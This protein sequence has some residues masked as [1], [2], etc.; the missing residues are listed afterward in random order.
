[1]PGRTRGRARGPDSV[2]SRPA[3]RRGVQANAVRSSPC[4][5][6]VPTARLVVE[7]ADP[8]IEARIRYAFSAYA[9]L[10]GLRVVPSGTADVI[11]GPRSPGEPGGRDRAR[12]LP[13]PR[14]TRSP[15]PRPRGSTACRASTRRRR[16]AG[17]ARR[18]LR[19]AGRT[20]RGGVH[21]PRR[22]RAG[23]AAAHARRHSRARPARAVGQPVDRPAA[24]RGPRGAA[25]AAGRPAVAVRRPPHL[26]GQPRHRP[27]VGPPVVNG[28]RVVENIGI[29]LL[30]RR[31]PRTA[32]QIARAALRR[33]ARGARSAVGL[34]EVLAGEAERGVRC[35]L[36]GG[37]RVAAPARPGLPARRRARAA[38]RCVPSPRRATRS[39]SHGSY[40]SL[41]RPGQL[42]REYRLLADGRLPARRRAPALAAAPRRRAV[43]GLRGRPGRRGTR[44]AAIPTT[45]ATGTAPPSRSCPTTWPRSGRSRS[46]RSRW[47]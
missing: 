11:V 18:D 31:D 7:T 22:G 8:R 19:M 23:P 42:A 6:S 29:A 3:A 21:R 27:P 30:Q 13:A 26:R 44:R 32:A 15:R 4:A 5:V 46:W 20:A 10:H 12:R 38:R 36:H 25:A 1:M 43:R 45:S 41:E 9:A 24:R 47:W 39:R 2:R 17:P 33:A 14:R 28:R 16:C 40:R 37:G 35:D 34:R